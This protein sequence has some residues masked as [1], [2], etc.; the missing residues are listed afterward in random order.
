VTSLNLQIDNSAI[1]I[2]F[3]ESQGQLVKSC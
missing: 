3:P 2:S 1:F